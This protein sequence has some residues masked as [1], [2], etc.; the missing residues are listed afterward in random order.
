VKADPVYL[1]HIRDAIQRI[2]EYTRGGQGAFFA[3]SMVQD[4][5]ER[6]HAHKKFP[7]ARKDGS[8]IKVRRQHAAELHIQA[9]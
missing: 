5:K 4:A 8:K 2:V 7:A 1:L 9:G 6:R 3:S